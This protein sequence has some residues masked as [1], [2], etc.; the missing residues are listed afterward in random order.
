MNTEDIVQRLLRRHPHFRKWL[1][2]EAAEDV[3]VLAL[4]FAIVDTLG[5]GAF[6]CSI[7]T[8]YRHLIAEI[9][10]RVVRF[11]RSL[12]VPSEAEFRAVERL[13]L[14]MIFGIEWHRVC[15]RWIAPTPRSTPLEAWK[16]AEPTTKG[17]RYMKRNLRDQ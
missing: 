10:A 4:Q 13:Y 8:Q 1:P 7:A 6:R 17:R 3:D 15:D 5:T 9:K 2:E 16:A 14:P 11:G 12:R